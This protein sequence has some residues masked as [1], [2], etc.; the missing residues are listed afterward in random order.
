M[1]KPKGLNIGDNIPYSKLV[2]ESKYIINE[3]YTVYIK[4]YEVK[5]E[6]NYQDG[7]KYSMALIKNGKRVLG[8]DNHEGKGHHMHRGKRELN[9]EF[10]D[11]WQT[12]AD[13]CKEV[14]KIIENDKNKKY[15]N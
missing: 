9:Y 11:L 2:Y 7:L 3:N 1:K 8:Y 10:V 6:I 13:F 12:I 5:K 15:N 4:A 14:D